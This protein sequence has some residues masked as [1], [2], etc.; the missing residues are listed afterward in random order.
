M[1]FVAGEVS[2]VGAVAMGL[3]GIGR[4]REREVA[5]WVGGGEAFPGP[6]V[7]DRDLVVGLTG[8]PRDRR[9]AIGDRATSEARAT[10]PPPPPPTQ[11]PRPP[12]PPPL[13]PP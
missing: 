7:I 9:F 10:P 11:E 2:G 6:S 13:A 5:V 12:P 4:H 8:R 1:P 3:G